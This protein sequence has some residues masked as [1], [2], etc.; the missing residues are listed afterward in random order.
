MGAR[1]GRAYPPYRIYHNVAYV[2]PVFD[3]IGAGGA[4]NATSV[5]WTHTATVGADVFAWVNTGSGSTS[6]VTYG[7]TSMTLILGV[8]N[9]NNSADGYLSLW[10]L[11]N[12]P[13][14]SNTVVASF[15]GTVLSAAN[16]V[17][18]LRVTGIGTTTSVFGNGTSQSQTVS[19]VNF[20]N[21]AI[22]AF[23]ASTSTLSSNWGGASG[24]TNRYHLNG[25]N[26]ECLISIS[27]TSTTSTTFT[28][29]TATSN[30]SGIA[31][32]VL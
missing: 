3:A 28:N 9:N 17:S 19:G 21:I 14:G 12:A 25:T 32:Q 8:F 31:L 5:S 15:S 11:T 2:S 18:Y 23:G 27:D 4:A 20:G 7:G 29:S 10:H 22:Q 13:A 30:W 16:T 26:G 1:F 6:S 24:G